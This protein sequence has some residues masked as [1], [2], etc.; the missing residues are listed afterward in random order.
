METFKSFKTNLYDLNADGFTDIA[1][2][3]FQYQAIHNA[4]YRAFLSHL[5][6]DPTKVNRL[7]DI[8]FMPISFFKSQQVKAGAWEA[9]VIFTSSGTT[10]QQM[11]RHEVRDLQF[12][13]THSRRCFEFFFGDLRNYN[14]L[15]LLPSY[16]ERSG[17]S[18]IAMMEYF[19]QESHSPLS[20]FY[21]HDV[22]RL[23]HD[24]A[25]AKGDH[26][27]TIVWGV[28]FALTDLA[29]QHAPDLGDCMVFE[30]GGMKGRRKEMTRDELHLQ[31]TQAFG[32]QQIYSEYGMT[33]LLSQ[34]YLL[35][36]DGFRLP[37]WMK[38]IIRDITDPLSKGLQSQTGGIN[39]IDLA[40]WNT[41]SFIETE[42]LGRVASNG[43]FEVLGRMDNSDVRGCNLLIG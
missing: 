32:V 24:V 16:L 31:L 11:S 10:G 19:I 12:Y 36:N 14:F 33:E 39:V 38:V 30:T 35:S 2:K 18:L 17:S 43:N 5:K 37:P 8:P 29:E 34:A 42:D 1:L 25:L 4:P 23:L 22:E 40:N 26:R 28:S 3:V 20:G 6:V 13:L 27:K 41:I 7:E 9:E 15:A 21:L